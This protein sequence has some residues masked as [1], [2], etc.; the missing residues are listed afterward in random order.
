MTSRPVLT[1]ADLP[2]MFAEGWALPKPDA[3]LAHF[4]PVIG[5]DATFRQPMFPDAHGPAEIEQMF[6]RLFVLLPHLNVTVRRSAIAGDAVFIES[7]CTAT[8]GRAAVRFGVCDRFLI[9]DGKVAE[10]R[11][12]SDPLPVLLAVLA[13]PANWPRVIRARASRMP[14]QS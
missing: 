13:H 8:L 10:R 11:A 4:L 12:F 3:F 6:R 1:P 5:A 9:R 7:G 2:G 14:A